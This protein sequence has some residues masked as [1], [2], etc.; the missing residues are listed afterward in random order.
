MFHVTWFLL[1]TWQKV[2][3]CT[4]E[5][6]GSSNLHW[7]LSAFKTK[8]SSRSNAVYQPAG[9]P[10]LLYC[11]HTFSAGTVGLLLSYWKIPLLTATL[12][13]TA[14]S[15]PCKGRTWPSVGCVLLPRLSSYLLSWSSYHPPTSSFPSGKPKPPPFNW[16]N[17]WDFTV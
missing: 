1:K 4:L 16:L 14:L 12:H 7:Q 9:P 2:C 5:T 13:K 10:P 17:S 11:G 8:F 3:P 15:L 6:A